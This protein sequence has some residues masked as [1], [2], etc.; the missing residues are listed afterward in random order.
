MCQHPE[1]MTDIHQS[2]N[3]YYFKY[4]G[5]VFSILG[6]S[7]EHES[8][9][10]TLYLYPQWGN[11]TSVLAHVCEYEPQGMEEVPMLTFHAR[12]YPSVPFADLWSTVQGRHYNIDSVFDDILSEAG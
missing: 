8:G 11:T 10:H 1:H 5:H 4:K 9:T 2:G 7:T 6:R 3:E 12:D